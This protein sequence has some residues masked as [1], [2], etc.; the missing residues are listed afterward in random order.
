MNPVRCHDCRP[1]CAVSMLNTR[2]MSRSC[3]TGPCAG[4]FPYL[5]S[6]RHATP[7]RRP[8]Y[9]YL[10]FNLD[11]GMHDPP[12]LPQPIRCRSRVIDI[13]AVHL[14]RVPKDPKGRPNRYRRHAASRLPGRRRRTRASYRSLKIDARLPSVAR[15]ITGANVSEGHAG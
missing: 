9:Q 7:L 13:E 11:R 12:V 1:R 2:R 8:G 4:A 10:P 3:S 6:F 15:F 14:P 5:R